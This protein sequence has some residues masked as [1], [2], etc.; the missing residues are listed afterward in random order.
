MSNVK[1]IKTTKKTTENK[2]SAS[3]GTG[4]YEVVGRSFLNPRFGSTPVVRLEGADS[5]G[6]EFDVSVRGPKSDTPKVAFKIVGVL[7]NPET[8]KRVKEAYKVRRP[9]VIGYV[10]YSSNGKKRI[11]DKFFPLS[12]DTEKKFYGSYLKAM[13]GASLEGLKVVYGDKA[14]DVKLSL[15]T[16]GAF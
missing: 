3:A 9:R 11:S 2:A 5:N 10:V 16:K 1:T 4:R 15:A 6:A 14:S 7:G 12:G 8:D 13:R